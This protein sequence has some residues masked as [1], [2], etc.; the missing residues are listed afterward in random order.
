MQTVVAKDKKDFFNNRAGVA[1]WFIFKP[2]IQIWVYFVGSFDGRGWCIL[3]PFS[4]FSGRLVYFP[5]L[6]HFYPFWYVVARK[7]WQPGISGS[8]LLEIET[9]LPKRRLCTYIPTKERTFF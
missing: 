7:I 3:W 1:R 8:A 6:L 5:L 2:K 9:R 4:Q